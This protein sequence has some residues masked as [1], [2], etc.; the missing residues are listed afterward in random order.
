M[1]LVP[2]DGVGKE[3][4]KSVKSIFKAA[5]VPI[6]WEQF[7]LSGHGALDD[8]LMQETLNS[9]RRNKVGLKGVLYTPISQTGHASFNVYMRKVPLEFLH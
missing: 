1:T 7:D 3:L 4:T 6:E 9:L 5:Q 8:S 2:G